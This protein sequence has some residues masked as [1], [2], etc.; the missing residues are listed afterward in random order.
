MQTWVLSLS[1]LRVRLT[2]AVCGLL[3]VTGFNGVRSKLDY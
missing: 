2:S 3:T 1:C